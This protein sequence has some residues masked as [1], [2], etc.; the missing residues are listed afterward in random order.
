MARLSQVSL[1]LAFAY[2]TVVLISGL[3]LDSHL[4]SSSGSFWTVR[5]FAATAPR[6]DANIRAT[7]ALG[8]A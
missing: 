1:R 5:A 6:P 7:P 8:P 3:Q 4:K 2:I